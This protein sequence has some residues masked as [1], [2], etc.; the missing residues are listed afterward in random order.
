MNTGFRYD[1]E[2]MKKVAAEALNG[3]YVALRAKIDSLDLRSVIKKKNPYLYRAKGMGKAADIVSALVDAYISSSEETIFGSSFFEPIAI[4][5]SGGRKSTAEGLDLEIDLEGNICYAIAVKSG[6]AAF[7]DSSK[8]KQKEN[9]ESAVSR[10]IQGNILV[11]PIIGYGYGRKT[12]RK[13]MIYQEIAGQAFWELITG[14][15]EFYKKLIDYMGDAPEENCKEFVKSIEKTKNRFTIEFIKDFCDPDGAIDWDKLVQFNSG[16]DGL[17]LPRRV[18][19]KDE[20]IALK[21][22]TEC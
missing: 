19:I 4:A 8:K 7:N 10:G 22:S 1:E 5:A 17:K 20:E 11:K 18:K 12:Q 15:S 13:Q 9:F 16:K 6:T 21:S 14:D 3:Y 2:Q